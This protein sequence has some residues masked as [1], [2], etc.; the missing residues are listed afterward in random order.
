MAPRSGRHLSILLTTAAAPLNTPRIC[1][2]Y[3]SYLICF[4]CLFLYFFQ[5]ANSAWRLIIREAL[6][7][8]FFYVLQLITL[9]LIM[10][11]IFAPP[12][13]ANQQLLAGLVATP[14]RRTQR[15]DLFLV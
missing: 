14:T 15:L 10:L 4:C 13:P 5:A 3:G 6:F 11:I 12:Q 1:F 9:S 2:F 7:N 8:L